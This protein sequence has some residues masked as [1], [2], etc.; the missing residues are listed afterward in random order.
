MNDDEQYGHLE[1]WYKPEI[2]LRILVTQKCCF[3]C[4]LLLFVC[5]LVFLF[6]VGFLCVCWGGGGGGGGGL[7]LSSSEETDI[8]SSCMCVW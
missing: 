8:A 3:V 5:L 2:S 6:V 1:L 7:S 4:L